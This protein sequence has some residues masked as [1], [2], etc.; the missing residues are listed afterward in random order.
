M[1]NRYQLRP[2]AALWPDL[3]GNIYCIGR[4]YADHAKELGNS[5]PTEPVIF[6][7]APSALR[8]LKQGP[9]AFPTETFHHELEL[10]LLIGQNINSAA[11]IDHNT[12]IAL[13]LALDLTRR[14]VQEQLKKQSLPWTLAKSFAG[15]AILSAF[16][17][18]RGIDLT[19]ID[20]QLEVNGEIK[21]QGHTSDMIFPCRSILGYL[22]LQ[23]P[24][25]IGDLIFTGTPA[26]VGPLRQGDRLKVSSKIL[27]LSEEGIL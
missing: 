6:L 8:D 19:E 1:T 18:A 27:S 7:K 2:K 14:S 11:E 23:Q 5:I 12:V 15:S 21:Q 10:C 4:N 9:L 16:V 26:G 24:L 20:L 17:A 22:C 13:S 25:Q 3:S